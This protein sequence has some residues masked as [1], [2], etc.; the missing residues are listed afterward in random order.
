MHS[1]VPFDLTKY[2]DL[3]MYHLLLEIHTVCQEIRLVSDRP[4]SNMVFTSLSNHY[5]VPVIN[6]ARVYA[7]DRELPGY[8]RILQS[9]LKETIL[10]QHRWL[11]LPIWFPL[12]QYITQW[13]YVIIILA[14]DWPVARI[15]PTEL[16]RRQF[17]H[18][19]SIQHLLMSPRPPSSGR[20]HFIFWHRLL[21]M[22]QI[23]LPVTSFQIS[24]CWKGSFVRN[25]VSFG[26]VLVCTE[27]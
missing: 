20:P 11:S 23:R 21:P 4:Y 9:K 19:P 2:D 1:D 5:Q 16:I 14:R 25:L 17:C 26:F 7:D 12:N 3:N 27:R 18:H 8:C 13:D 15:W 10:L 6:E 24:R 22:L